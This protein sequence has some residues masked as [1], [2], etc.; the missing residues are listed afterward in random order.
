MTKLAVIKT[1][2]KQYIVKEGDTLVIEKLGLDVGTHVDFNEVLFTDHDGDVKVGMPLLDSVVVGA[3][4]VGQGRLKKINVVKFKRKV[5]YRR[6]IGHR[7]A[8]SKVLI[9]TIS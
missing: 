7:Q 9:Q 4:V 5:R 8:Y 3:K 2:G 6:N 1:G